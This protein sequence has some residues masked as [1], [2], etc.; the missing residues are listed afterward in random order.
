MALITFQKVQMSFILDWIFILLV[1]IAT[2]PFAIIKPFE[3]EFRLNDDTISHPY[4]EGESFSVPLLIFCTVGLPVILIVC[5]HT[6]TKD[7]KY[8]LHQS[9]MGF[10]VS[11]SLT[12]FVTT[13]IKVSVGRYRPDF[14]SRCQVNITKVEEIYN[15]YKFS[16]KIDFGPRNLYNT[17]ICTNP[18]TSVIDEGRKSFPS[19]HSSFAFSTL[20]FLS[21][22]LAGKIHLYDGNYIF[23]KLV[24]A[25][26]PNILALYIAITRISDYRH[27]WQDIVVGSFI[28]I[29][30]SV[31]SYFYYFPFLNSL[32]PYKQLQGRLTKY[33]ILSDQPG[34]TLPI[35]RDRENEYISLSLMDNEES[36]QSK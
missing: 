32:E 18:D 19:G 26:A 7:L 9:I 4:K 16:N 33:N 24:A 20:T 5:Y 31:L 13:L 36:K 1:I 14:I 6:Y 34:K 8:S 25:L 3:R 27:H 22:F 11:I 23:W 35:F 2:V 15:S 12:M 17:T 10:C 28:G 21:L 30:F 29:F